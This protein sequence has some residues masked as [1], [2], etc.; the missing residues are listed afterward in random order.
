MKTRDVTGV[1]LLS[2][3]V[4]VHANRFGHP[5]TKSFQNFA[6]EKNLVSDAWIE[7]CDIVF[8]EDFLE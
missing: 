4:L 3:V 1:V 7:A 8:N 2:L 5:V 6:R